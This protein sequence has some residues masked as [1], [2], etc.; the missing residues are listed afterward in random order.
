[1]IE[2]SPTIL[3]IQI[4]VFLAGM[5]LVWKFFLSPFNRI[6]EE[7]RKKLSDNYTN[8]EQIR[9]DAQKIHKEYEQKLLD[10]ENKTSE[11]FS[12]T[13]KQAEE[14]RQEI[15]RQA[16]EQARIL[17]KRTEQEL[18]SEKQVLIGELRDEIGTLGVMMA[19]K[20]IQK[21]FAREEHE[22]LLEEVAGELD[23]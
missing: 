16:H 11:M 18:A 6:L 1:M 4:A 13:E 7:R 8:A 20:I 19:E 10:L 5:G 15:I 21:K 22:K 12:K 17:L 9:S 3:L 14:S 23:K 2:I